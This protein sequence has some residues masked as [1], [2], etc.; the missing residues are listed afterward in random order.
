MAYLRKEKEYELSGDYYT[1]IAEKIRLGIPL[2]YEEQDDWEN[3]F[4]FDDASAG[5]SLGLPG[6][7]ETTKGGTVTATSYVDPAPKVI[8]LTNSK[9]LYITVTT[10]D[11]QKIHLSKNIIDQLA[12][13]KGDKHPIYLTYQGKEYPGIIHFN[14]EA[15]E[16]YKAGGKK[17][18]EVSG[19]YYVSSGTFPWLAGLV[20]KSKVAT[21]S[22]K[23]P[24]TEEVGTTPEE[25]ATTEITSTTPEVSSE[26]VATEEKK[27][28]STPYFKHEWKV[29]RFGQK[30]LFIWE[31]GGTT[32]YPKFDE[33]NKY[34]GRQ[35]Q[36]KGLSGDD[37]NFERFRN[38]PLEKDYRTYPDYG[39]PTYWFKKTVG[40]DVE[41]TVDQE[42]DFADLAEFDFSSE[43][44]KHTGFH[45]ATWAF[46]PEFDYD[47][48]TL[49]LEDTS[50]DR[51]PADQKDYIGEKDTGAAK[52]NAP[53]GLKLLSK[54][55]FGA[56]VVKDKE[57]AEIV[58]KHGDTV[59]KEAK[60]IKHS[61]GFTYVK[62][63]QGDGWAQTEY[64]IDPSV[65]DKATLYQVEEG[66]TLEK[67]VVKKY[68]NFKAETGKDYRTIV[69]AIYILNKNNPKSG[70]YFAKEEDESFLESQ[71]SGARK[72]VDGDMEKTRQIYKTIRVKKD[73]DL[74]LPGMDYINKQYEAGELGKRSEFMNNA[75]A[76]GK[77]VTGFS[78]GVIEGLVKGGYEAVE[79]VY[80]MGKAVVEAFIDLFTGELLKKAKGLYDKLVNMTWEGMTEGLGKAKDMIS[81]EWEKF[82]KNW[83]DPNI[84]DRWNFR[85]ELVGRIVLEILVAIITAGIGGAASIITK[86]NKFAPKL[87]KLLTEVVETVNKVRRKL[88]KLNP[89]KKNTKKPKTDLDV[90]KAGKEIPENIKIDKVD[91]N[92]KQLKKGDIDNH[93]NTNKKKFDAEAE[94]DLDPSVK[95]DHDPEHYAQKL[96]ALATAKAIC[97]LYDAMV[98]SPPVSF[99]EKV[100]T[101]AIILS[102][103]SFRVESKGKGHYTILMIGSTSE[104]DDD[105]SVGKEG[106]ELLKDKT[107]RNL[108]SEELK[109]LVST[110]VDAQG[111]HYIKEMKETILKNDPWEMQDLL[112]DPIYITKV[113]GKKYI[114]DGHNRIKA[115]SELG[116]K[117]DVIELSSSKAK[118]MCKSKME[119]ITNKLF[120]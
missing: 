66:D 69:M 39:A 74:W 115:F 110:E 26:V 113:N 118:N 87:A 79:G 13:K 91:P 28:N 116:K 84:Y 19:T 111:D 38:R 82:K 30:N 7:E 3:Q 78:A 96:A 117:L 23:V 43:N 106:E 104:I 15:Y 114:L 72:V 88:D 31:V 22:E 16:K 103:I 42:G 45:L 70:I 65:D 64:L 108:N 101:K 8:W 36:K 81:G 32:H 37:L 119:D 41:G 90:P 107:P 21:G 63:P 56:P 34:I 92:I 18:N 11:Y 24:V 2:S 86:I 105:Y 5:H 75:I 46:D 59:Y 77:G 120:D 83:N 109:N 10:D 95:K 89:L 20:P 57:G 25:S 6:K 60:S 29:D 67:L 9:S 98:P 48:E 102:G 27:E 44:K 17:D 100:L 62:T 35:L 55:I 47:A 76:V 80:D 71:Y 61:D 94:K 68:P 53:A 54:P 49:I 73:G 1:D 4:G 85:G 51:I 58:F 112:A 33:S 50:E 40:W 52:V 14:E 93:Y 97:E 99:V 12:L